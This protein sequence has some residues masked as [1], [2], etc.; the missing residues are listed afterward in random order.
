MAT[1]KRRR[2]PTLTLRRIPPVP[3]FSAP[4]WFERLPDW[5]GTGGALVVLMAVSAFIRTRYL[6][7]ELWMDEAN[8]VGIASHPLS[9]IPG[10]LRHGGGAP[11]YYLLL[12]FWM[13]A[14]GAGAAALHA[15]SL[16]LGLLAVPLSLW[17][18][19]SLF[20]R[21]AAL[22]TATLVAFSAFLTKYAVETRPY[23]L[24]T[25][26]GLLA[27]AALLHAF[28]HRHRRWLWALGASLT[29]MLYT[30]DWAVF[31]W[32]GALIAVAAIWWVSAERRPLALDALTA[33]GLPVLL[34]LPWVIAVVIHQAT[35]ATDPFHYAP[36][37]GATVPKDLLGSDRVYVT[38]GVAALVGLL[39]PLLWRTGAGA[40][41]RELGAL[42]VLIVAALALAR[43][44]AALGL[45]AWAS[46]YM[47]PIAAAFLI[48]AGWGCARSGVIG[49]A[50]LVLACAFTANPG[51]F[52]APY[53]SD[54]RDV[55]G[56]LQSDLRPGD[57]VLVAQ[58]E[59]APLAWYYLPGGLRYQ[60]SL[61]P[62]G[63]PSWMNWD[64]AYA[65]LRT[66]DPA[67]QATRLIASLRPGQRLLFIRPLTEGEKAWARPW[68]ALVRRRAAQWGAALAGAPQLRALPGAWA[69]HDYP[70]SCC[71]ASS[72]L[73]Y[74][75]LPGGRS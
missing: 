50:A 57:V 6:G 20:G 72:A 53:K 38:L 25:V 13:Q 41:T 55:G 49:L 39:P 5:L 40:H 60:T 36:L 59:Q 1:V 4:G 2:S 66:A 69:P 10:L 15:L 54:M 3:D 23:E 71:I 30:D 8:T 74:V 68:S 75:K 43:I 26:L 47:G 51:S 67:A 44:V 28:V 7:G 63:H 35:S 37:L 42:V 17:L 21:R 11:L 9:A 61:G 24:M 64:G 27:V 32:A 52:V 18:A 46:R 12:H 16:M 14:F 22:M 29:A 58:P 56:E 45:P 34:Y 48:L 19:W 65:R 62:D 31:F 73:V 33:F 70:G